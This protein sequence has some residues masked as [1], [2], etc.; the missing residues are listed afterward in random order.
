MRN[1]IKVRVVEAEGGNQSVRLEALTPEGRATLG[2]LYGEL[3]LWHGEALTVTNRHGEDGDAGNPSAPL[4]ALQFNPYPVAS[5]FVI[6]RWTGTGFLFHKGGYAITSDPEEAYCYNHEE[7]AGFV[8]KMNER[9]MG[10][11]NAQWYVK[12]LLDA[13]YAVNNLKGAK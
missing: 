9:E 5:V 1:G 3:R 13:R 6:A 2:N 4:E 7:A 12:S 10:S 8:P 11:E